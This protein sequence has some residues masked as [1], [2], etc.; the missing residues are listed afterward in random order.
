MSMTDLLFSRLHAGWH[1][2]E[3]K[4]TERRKRS[5][6]SR[7]A[8]MRRRLRKQGRQPHSL[9]VAAPSLTR[10]SVSQEQLLGRRGERRIP[11]SFAVSWSLVR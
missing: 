6:L 3:R 11:V 5:L 10:A 7:D 4:D 1:E 8:R 2:G 9:T